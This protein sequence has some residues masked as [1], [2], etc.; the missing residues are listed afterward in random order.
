MGDFNMTVDDPGFNGLI[1]DHDFSAL[2]SQSTCFKSINPACVDKATTSKLTRFMNTLTFET[3]VSDQDKLIR[4][5][6]RSTFS[7]VVTK[8]FIMKRLKK[9]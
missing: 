4:T 2:I 8:T 3:G 5:V 6:L 9:N 7:K 1:D